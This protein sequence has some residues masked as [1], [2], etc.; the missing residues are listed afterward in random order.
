MLEI[1]TF[2]L[3][4]VETNTYLAADPV[5]GEAVCIDPAWDGELIAAEVQRRNWQVKAIW[6]THAHFDHFGGAAKLAQVLR[7]A[8]P[9]ALHELEKPLWR[10]GGG[11]PWFGLQVEPGPEP[12]IDLVHGQRLV[13][14]SNQFDVRH[15]PGHTPGHVIFTCAAQAVAFVG[16]V[17]FQGG[18]GRTDFPGGNYHRLIQSLKQQVLTLP[19]DTRLLSGHGPETS[20]GIERETNPFLAQ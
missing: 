4:P 11:A 10:L 5:S 1:V 19:D 18:I 6:L 20:V 17:I 14:G 12:S 2:V 7:P 13:L 3:G 16:D 9:V 15:V 8:P